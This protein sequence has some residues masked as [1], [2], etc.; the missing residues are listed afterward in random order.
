MT[1]L[2]C[3]VRDE[4]G[5]EHARSTDLELC[6]HLADELDVG[7]EIEIRFIAYRVTNES[8]MDPMYDL[9]NE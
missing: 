3:I 9:F 7:A 2:V 6:R 8:L 1:D 5:F 4:L